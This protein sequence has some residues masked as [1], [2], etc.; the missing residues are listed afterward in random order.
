MKTTA[1]WEVKELCKEFPGLREVVKEVLSRL[2]LEEWPSRVGHIGVKRIDAD[3]LKEQ[4]EEEEVND[5]HWMLLVWI[6]GPLGIRFM[7]GAATIL[8]GGTILDYMSPF[9]D[10]LA[11][12]FV[13]VEVEHNESGELLILE[14]TVWKAPSNQT[15]RQLIRRV[16]SEAIPVDQAD[17]EEEQGRIDNR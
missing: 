16:R 7:K 14:I 6:I 13:S 9:M 10:A 15:I 17:L 5:P 3:T 12:R 11:R 2:D 4:L 8:A 1:K